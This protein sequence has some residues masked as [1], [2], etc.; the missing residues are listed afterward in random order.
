MMKHKGIRISP[1]MGVLLCAI[2]GGVVWWRW[3]HP[4]PYCEVNRDG[5]RTAEYRMCADKKEYRF[6]EPVHITFTIKNISGDTGRQDF[7]PIEFGNGVEP[8][9]DICDDELYACW[10][11]NRTLTD[12]DKRFTLQLRES[13]TLTWTMPTSPEYLDHLEERMR[14][15]HDSILRIDLLGCETLTSREHMECGPYYIIIYGHMSQLPHK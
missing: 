8:A 13:R 2:V 11:N 10:S 4:Q 15:S 14:Y 7:G 9:M 5:S 3:Q 6:G 1:L 12:D